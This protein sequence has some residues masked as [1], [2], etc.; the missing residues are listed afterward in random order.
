MPDPGIEELRQLLERFDTGLLTTRGG[1]GHFHTRP[2]ALQAR[3]IEDGLWFATTEG[4]A[5]VADL[6]ADPHCGV[7][8]YDKAT[9]VSVSGEAT[10]VRDRATV[11]RLWSASWRPW[12]PDGPDQEDLV[13]IHLRPE[14][15]EFVH[16]H[17]GR[18]QV[19][20][21]MARRL[22]THGRQ[23]PAPKVELDLA[24]QP[25][26]IGLRASGSGLRVKP[27]AEA[28]GFGRDGGPGPQ[29]RG[30]GADRRRSESSRRR[31]WAYETLGNLG[32]RS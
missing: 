22:V 30:S 18:L 9:Y 21:T 20:F 4:S 15:A 3:S 13:L 14:H 16:P 32:V 26:S 24:P 28:A 10:L 8:F 27:L 19:L 12:F 23:E 11:H 29:R 25:S 5:K 7:A 6:E 1:D 17:T 31:P 2:M